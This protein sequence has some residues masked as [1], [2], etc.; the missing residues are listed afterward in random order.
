MFAIHVEIFHSNGALVAFLPRN[1]IEIRKVFEKVVAIHS[2]AAFLTSHLLIKKCAKFYIFLLITSEN[3]MD[4]TSY[5][6]LLG[7]NDVLTKVTL[8]RSS[9]GHLESWQTRALHSL[10]TSPIQSLFEWEPIWWSF[11]ANC[12]VS[13]FSKGVFH[14]LF[15]K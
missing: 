9:G 13:S 10:T 15:V 3:T 2:S 6:K 4:L 8:Y 14:A 11:G 7:W 12:V 5:F 1:L